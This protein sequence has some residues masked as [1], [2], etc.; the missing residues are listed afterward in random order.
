MT[1]FSSLLERSCVTKWKAQPDICESAVNKMI[2]FR[3][4]RVRATAAGTPGADRSRAS[5]GSGARW[6]RLS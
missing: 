4:P 3:H 5:R 6:S 1:Q 2:S